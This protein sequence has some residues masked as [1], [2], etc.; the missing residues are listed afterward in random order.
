M[1]PVIT[2][3]VLRDESGPMLTRAMLIGGGVI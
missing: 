3:P 1:M 2:G